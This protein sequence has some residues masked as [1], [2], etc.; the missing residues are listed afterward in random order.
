[1]RRQRPYR[2]LHLHGNPLPGAK[3]ARIALR[4][5]IGGDIEKT[6]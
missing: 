2:A 1:L 3:M 5:R 4:R 6:L